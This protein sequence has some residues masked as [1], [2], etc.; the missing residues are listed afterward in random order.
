MTARPSP[1]RRAAPAPRVPADEQRVDLGLFWRDGGASL[2]A[3]VGRNLPTL[4]AGRTDSRQGVGFDLH[5]AKR[6]VRFVIDRAQIQFLRKYLTHQARR[7][8]KERP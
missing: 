7:L 6:H 5:L 3:G 2:H 4:D 8:V 1:R